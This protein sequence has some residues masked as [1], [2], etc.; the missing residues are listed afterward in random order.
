[1]HSHSL[2]VSRDNQL[3]AAAL[4]GLESFSHV[5]VIFLFHENTNLH[6]GDGTQSKPRSTFS[7]AKVRP[8]QAGGE[9]VGV[10]AC[11]T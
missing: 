8:P 9:K 5:W 10:L 11:R 1:M 2:R 3:H 6:K 4:S 7:P